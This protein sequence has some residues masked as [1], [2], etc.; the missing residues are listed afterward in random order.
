MNEPNK[1]YWKETEHKIFL[2][3]L[4]LYGTKWKEV[5]NISVQEMSNRPNLIHRSIFTHCEG[6]S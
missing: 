6:S 5:R 1:G 2:E 3:A 4:F